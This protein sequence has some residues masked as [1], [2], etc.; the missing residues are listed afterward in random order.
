MPIKKVFTKFWP[1]LL[2]LFVWIA[3]FSPFF[4]KGLLPIPADIITGVYYPWLDYKWGFLTGVPV[5]NPLIS[6][7]PSLLY[8][9]RALV[10][11]QYRQLR[12]PLWNPYY[13]G[14]MPLLANFQ[15]AAFSY[16]NA[17]FLFLPKALAWSAG[18][19]LSPFLTLVA[20]YLFLRNKKLG[21]FP[22][23]LGGV[24]FALSGFQIAWLEYNVHGHT[25]LFLPL[26]LLFIDKILGD[27]KK[28][29]LFGLPI[30]LAFQIFAGYIPVVIYSYLICGLYILISYIFPWWQKKSFDWKS[31]VLLAVFWLWGVALASIQL[32]P[33]F[34][35]TQ[36]SIRKIDPIVAGS[37]ASYLP[38]INLVTAI[39]PD[40]FGNPATGNYFGNAF[41]DNFYFFAGTGVLILIF[42]SLFFLK[43]EKGIVFGWVAL[44]FSCILV[45][46]NP[47]GKTLEQIL[48]L[49]GGVAARAL[50]ITVFALAVL[51]AYGFEKLITSGG[52]KKLLFSLIPVLVLFAVAFRFS[53]GFQNPVFQQVAQRNLL[54]P[55]AV[56][57]FSGFC[58]LFIVAS[59]FKR[60]RV[61]L[62]FVFVL[63]VC[64]QLLYSAR[65]YLPFSQ[66]HL[67]FPKTPILDYLVV[68]ATESK[69]PFRVE[70]GEVVPQNFLMPYGLQT[71]SGYDALL[72]KR[73]GEFLTLLQTGNI[74]ER[75]SRVHLLNNYHSPLFPLLNVKYILA[76]KTDEKG[77]YSPVGKTPSVFEDPRFE[78]AFEDKTVVIY[79]DKKALPRAFWV[80]DYAVAKNSESLV[81]LL[82]TTDLSQKVILEKKLTETYSG[83]KTVGNSIEWQ[84]YSPT[85]IAFVAESEKAGI[86]FLSD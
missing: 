76:K 33:G 7:I 45:F 57:V 75:I 70:L 46:E 69:E 60:F 55:A 85:R 25:A 29:F 5:K 24:V 64:A 48:F 56:F 83:G 36:N 6:D 16:V 65:K 86:V 61:V 9:W 51:S 37:K 62:S 3:L 22:S 23:L 79:E 8:P 10:I 2:I 30:L 73:T 34:E 84:E 58:L 63:A 42:F 20:V 52:L 72:P 1:V 27:K 78:V 81:Q 47:L 17:F 40:F 32:M 67:L 35:L 19:M 71:V 77:I 44:I 31:L 54:I 15:S 74:E 41:Y 68:K 4:L 12:W 28:I 53:A 14:G 18:V 49:S 26:L 59:K 39:A 43:K 11:D 38:P 21:V 13:F 82:K 66:S 80:Y 50:F